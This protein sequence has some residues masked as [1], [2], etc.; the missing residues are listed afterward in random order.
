MSTP[1]VRYCGGEITSER[2]KAKM[3]LVSGTC[4][5]CFRMLMILME[6][7]WGAIRRINKIFRNVL[8]VDSR[9]TRWELC[10]VS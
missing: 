8:F 1:G 10:I 2:E 7:R 9:I 4:G 5:W 3:V 6:L